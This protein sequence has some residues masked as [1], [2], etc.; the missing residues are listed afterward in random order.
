MA[1]KDKSYL[2]A[3]TRS[4][5]S[6]REVKRTPIPLRGIGGFLPLHFLWRDY[7]LWGVSVSSFTSS[8][9]TFSFHSRR[10]FLLR[11]AGMSQSLLLAFLPPPSVAADTTRLFPHTDGRKNKRRKK[12]AGTSSFPKSRLEKKR[13]VLS[14]PLFSQS[15]F[16]CSAR[17]EKGNVRKHRRR[18]RRREDGEKGE[19][20]N[21]T[22]GER[23]NVDGQEQEQM[24]ENVPRSGLQRHFALFMF[25]IFSTR[26]YA[27]FLHY[28]YNGVCNIIV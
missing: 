27:R 13:E 15:F 21:W 14:F 8:T 19:G 7:F 9:T 22:I 2:R 17:S 23:R 5:E 20:K 24:I 25:S 28:K 11:R 4:P 18:R 6:G 16:F 12:G 3:H 1:K 10:L 26:V